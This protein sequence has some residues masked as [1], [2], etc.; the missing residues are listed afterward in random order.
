MAEKKTT[1]KEMLIKL[2]TDMCWLKKQ[3]ANHLAHHWQMTVI[4]VGA[5]IAQA[6]ALAIALI[7][8]F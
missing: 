3:F 4:L 8:A 5:V 7:K 1:N 2:D 6:A